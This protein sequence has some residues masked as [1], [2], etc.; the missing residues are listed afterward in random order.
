MENNKQKDGEEGVEGE[1]DGEK[2]IQM[3]NW[4]E[5]KK[6]QMMKTN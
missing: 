5:K 4:M 2:K 3:E 6:N 1:L